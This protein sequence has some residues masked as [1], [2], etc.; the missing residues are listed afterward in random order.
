MNKIDQGR[1]D[2]EQDTAAV[3]YY[4]TGAFVVERGAIITPKEVLE[5]E[6]G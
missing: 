6:K 4:T 5:E 1:G 2:A 3:P